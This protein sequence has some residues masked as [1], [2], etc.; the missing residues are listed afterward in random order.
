MH[1]L[2]KPGVSLTGFK[3]LLEETLGR[4]PHPQPRQAGRRARLYPPAAL[5]GPPSTPRSTVS[6]H[7]PRPAADTA[8]LGVPGS[9]ISKTKFNTI[10]Q[11]NHSYYQFQRLLTSPRLFPGLPAARAESPRREEGES[12]LSEFPRPGPELLIEHPRA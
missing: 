5:A 2:M 9:E 11:N 1:Q 6:K 8:R 3:G 7:P 12:P 10:E 4:G